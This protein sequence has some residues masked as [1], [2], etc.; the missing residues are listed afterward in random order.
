MS[1]DT[2]NS[3]SISLWDYSGSG[4]WP[5]HWPPVRYRRLSDT[6]I[7]F[8]IVPPANTGN[9]LG[10]LHGGF[11]ATYAEHALGLFSQDKGDPSSGV[12]TVSLNLDYPSGG[13]VEVLLE[14]EAELLRETGRMQFIQ[15]R[16]RQQ[17]ELIVM[18]NGVLRKVAR[19]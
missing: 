12:V 2:H 15:I 1:G 13:K 14:G 3:D 19:G 10:G 11:L 17:G 16:L 6:R 8:V 9:R 7:D 4:L 18:A 5:E